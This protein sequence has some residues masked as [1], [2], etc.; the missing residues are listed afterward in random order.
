M[1]SLL[2]YNERS[3]SCDPASLEEIDRL[4][5]EA[6]WPIGRKL[7]LSEGVLPGPRA[8]QAAGVG[9]IIVLSGDGTLSS[10]ADALDGWDGTLLVLPGG[11]MNL[12]SR[13]LHGDL[14]PPEIVRAYLDG[15]GQVLRVPV[16]HAGDI[17]AYTGL[18]AGPTAAWG[19]VR[20]DLRNMDVA[21]LA[22][23]VPRAIAATLNEPG[24]GIAGSDQHYPAIFIEPR[25]NGLQAYGVLASSAGD[26][27]RHGWAWLSG[28][29][30]NGPS[31]SLAVRREMRLEAEGPTIDLLVD[32]EKHEATSPLDLHVDLSAVRFFA[33]QGEVAWR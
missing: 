5:A 15:D 6:G 14:S 22:T 11:T 4:F 21:A 25:P 17:V 28:D 27:F 31:E 12:L 10:V 33:A 16:I 7:P 1:D 8:A 9:L 13:A 24:V 23:N 18:I 29:F 20:E 3:G 19:D 2:I 26:L 32:G 30:R